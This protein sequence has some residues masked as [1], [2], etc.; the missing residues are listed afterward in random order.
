MGI[1]MGLSRRT[2]L[3]ATAALITTFFA[4]GATANARIDVGQLVDPS[5]SACPQ[6][7]TWLQTV[8][9]N[10][11]YVV[12]EAGVI[13]QWS[14]QGAGFVPTQMRLKV[15]RPAGGND[16]SIVGQSGFEVPAMNSVNT[17]NTAVTVAAGD[18]IGF[19][20][21]GSNFVDC[22]LPGAPG[23]QDSFANGDIQPGSTATFTH[24]G[25]QLDIAAVLEPD[26]DSD[27]QGD[28]TQDQ[29]LSPCPPA[30]SATITKRPK[31]KTKKKT[32]TF[33]FTA[34]EPGATFNCVLDGK[35]EF[36][37][38]TSPLTFKVKKGKHTFSVAATDAGGNSG[39]AATDGWKVKKKK[40]KK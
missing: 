23:Y 20:F 22:A 36:K 37:T 8:S 33:E 40:K 26:C 7:N 34:N 15:G 3:L 29:D 5:S 30:P 16:Y 1:G 24:E 13:T 10:N 28:E 39:A 18:I 32:A 21:V 19:Y 6:N 31:D 12:P 25:G 4:F 11:R 35:Q 38:C 17:Y 27:G 14:F 2:L 9:P